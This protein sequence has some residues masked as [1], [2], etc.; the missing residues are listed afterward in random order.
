[1][2][3][4]TG[5]PIMDWRFALFG[6]LGGPPALELGACGEASGSGALV[7]IGGGPVAV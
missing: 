6:K 4:R 2:G 7:G 1:M 5:T 3:G